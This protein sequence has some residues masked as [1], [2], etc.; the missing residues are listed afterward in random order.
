VAGVVKLKKSKRAP[1]DLVAI[2]KASGAAKFFDKMVRDI[3]ADYGG[4]RELS[5]S[6]PN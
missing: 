2:D 1:R 6:H 5:P 4:R 3:E